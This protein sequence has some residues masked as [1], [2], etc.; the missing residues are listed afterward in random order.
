MYKDV[1]LIPKIW[2][3]CYILQASF[4]LISRLPF[5]KMF[6]LALILEWRKGGYRN[7][8][9]GGVHYT[10]PKGPKHVRPGSGG[11]L[12]PQ[13]AI[14]FWTV[15]DEFW[16]LQKTVWSVD[17]LAYLA[18][19]EGMWLGVDLKDELFSFQLL[20]GTLQH[21][22]ILQE[23]STSNFLKYLRIDLFI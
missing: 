7:S 5:L 23:N 19:N 11:R 1:T 22:I 14:G 10:R 3:Q 2:C 16:A 4:R 12:R 6:F 17:N 8:E 15:S 9:R 18:E 13:E 21:Y 20:C